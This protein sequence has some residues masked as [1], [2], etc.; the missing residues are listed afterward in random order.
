[1]SGSGPIVGR[2]AQQQ[3]ACVY[4]CGLWQLSAPVC[5]CGFALD[6]CICV[7][8][9][10]SFV[11]IIRVY[12]RLRG[13]TVCVRWCI[14]RLVIIT[15][16]FHFNNTV[17]SYSKH[18]SKCCAA[19]LLLMQSLPW[20]TVLQKW[21]IAEKHLFFPFI[22]HV[23]HMHFALASRLQSLLHGFVGVITVWKLA[24][25][26]IKKKQNKKH[27]SLQCFKQ[28]RTNSSFPFGEEV[29]SCRMLRAWG[30]GCSLLMW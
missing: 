20:C 19:L 8:G 5:I 18:I 30:M 26:Q 23:N 15:F 1:M 10:R 6:L 25:N 21:V 13:V 24:Y 27:E 12:A 28:K 11:W 4:E 17:I 3:C 29:H 16:Y 9:L 2:Y 7:S 22:V 14:L